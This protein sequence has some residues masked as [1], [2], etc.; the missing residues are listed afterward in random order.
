MN[1]I[2]AIVYDSREPEW[3]KQLDWSAPSVDTLLETGDLQVL[4]ADNSILW[5]ER[6]TPDDFLGSLKDGRL[7]TQATRLAEFR[8]FDLIRDGKSNQWAY[9]VIT[10]FFTSQGDKVV[11]ERGV[12]GWTM[13]AVN[14][15]LLSI[16]EMGVFTIFCN[17]DAAFKECVMKLAER[18]RDDVQPVLP[19]RPGMLLGPKV[20]FLAGLPGIG[21]ERAQ[22][23]LDW[24]KHNVGHALMGLTDVQIKAPVPVSVRWNIRHMI[25]LEDDEE[26]SILKKGASQS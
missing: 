24:S 26:L 11:T 20:A 2:Q 18:K 16:Q 13:N 9:V 17:G 5:I 14:G 19:A 12:T 25:G 22:D 1:N 7:L 15:A 4:T 6:K 21:I 10:G 23:I 3:V 8:H